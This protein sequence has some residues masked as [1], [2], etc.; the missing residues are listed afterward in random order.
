[1]SPPSHGKSIRDAANENTKKNTRDPFF[2][3]GSFLLTSGQC[4][5]TTK[6][7]LSGNPGSASP[8]ETATSHT[9]EKVKSKK[10]AEK[11]LKRT[12]A[13][14]LLLLEMSDRDIAI[15]S[16]LSL[17]QV[18][19]LRSEFELTHRIVGIGENPDAVFA[20]A[21]KQYAKLCFGFENFQRSSVGRGE[22]AIAKALEKFLGL[23]MLLDN[24]HASLIAADHLSAPSTV[25]ARAY[26][27][28]LRDV[29]GF[30]DEPRKTDRAQV[31]VLWD[32]YMHEVSTLQE[33]YPSARKDLEESLARF[34]AERFQP[35]CQWSKR[36]FQF[37]REAV[38]SVDPRYAEALRLRYG[39]DGQKPKTQKEI[40][41]IRE[42][43][44]DAARRLIAGGIR[45]LRKSEHADVLRQLVLSGDH[46]LDAVLS[47]NKSLYQKDETLYQ[48]R[49][50]NA[51]FRKTEALRKGKK[52]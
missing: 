18:K 52:K 41:S 8:F 13:V 46:L 38:Q 49:K 50:E 1:M 31:K 27:E 30:H 16:D 10:Q 9:E 44:E 12:V 14:N 17:L 47:L 37:V 11:A 45:F 7:M 36:V 5:D 20:Q 3:K 19:R 32:A 28:L 21:F 33:P 34:V 15:C 25:S 51:K 22:R 24:M 23:E 48:L 35:S 26:Y 4:R 2:L 43:S 29:A 42:I 39:L 6:R 40:A